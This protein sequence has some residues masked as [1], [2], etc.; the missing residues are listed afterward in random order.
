[1]VKLITCPPLIGCGI[2]QGKYGLSETLK[3]FDLI[4]QSKRLVSVVLLR[5]TSG[6]IRKV[7]CKPWGFLKL[8]FGLYQPLSECLHAPGFS[9]AP[10]AVPAANPYLGD[11]VFRERGVHERPLLSLEAILRN[12]GQ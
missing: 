4:L 5:L 10:R 6:F 3:V 7:F 11:S 12:T 8:T 1:M 9:L 2:T